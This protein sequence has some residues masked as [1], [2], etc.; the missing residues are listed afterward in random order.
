VLT[1]FLKESV[2]G[3][4]VSH[5]D[6]GLEVRLGGGKREL[7]KTNFGVLNSAGTTTVVRG[8]LINETES[9]NELRIVDGATELGVNLNISQVNI[10]GASLINNL[11]YGIS[12][13]GG[14]KV[15]VMVD[16]LG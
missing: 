12:G 5:D 10:I 13:H 8:L 6:V 7:N 9:I 11:K 4:I 14:K 1:F 2:H 3:G 15:G 16:N